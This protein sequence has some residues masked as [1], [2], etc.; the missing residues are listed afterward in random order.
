M[1][2]LGTW[3]DDK[4]IV[5]QETG[6]LLASVGGWVMLTWCGVEAKYDPRLYRFTRR[7]VDCMTCLVKEKR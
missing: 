4:G 6:S 7:E 1:K 5:H 3:Q 2:R